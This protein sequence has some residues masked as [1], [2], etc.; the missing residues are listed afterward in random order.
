MNIIHL[1]I[2]IN[3]INEDSAVHTIVYEKNM[4]VFVGESS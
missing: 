3:T 2:I 4:Y 1:I